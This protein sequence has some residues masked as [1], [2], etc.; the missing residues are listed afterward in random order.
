MH[1]NNENFIIF[2]IFFE[3]Y[4]YRVLLFELINDSVTYQQYI[5]NILFKYLND[6]YQIY[7]NDIFIYSRIKKDHVKYVRL[8]F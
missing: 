2:V 7:L 6:F 3:A 1:L 8:I 4:K 5:D